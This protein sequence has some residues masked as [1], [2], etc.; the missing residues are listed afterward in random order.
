MKS[1]GQTHTGQ[2]V[3]KEEKILQT[4]QALYK[5]GNYEEALSKIRQAIGGKEEELGRKLGSMKVVKA[6]LDS[7]RIYGQTLHGL[8]RANGE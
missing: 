1:L 8:P 3:L 6:M 7:V 4:S 5:H 2:N